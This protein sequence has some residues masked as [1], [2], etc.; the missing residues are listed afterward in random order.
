MAKLDDMAF[1]LDKQQS[2]RATALFRHLPLVI[3]GRSWAT[4]ILVLLTALVKHLSNDRG[5][6]SQL[7]RVWIK[8]GSLDGMNRCLGHGTCHLG[9]GGSSSNP[10]V[11]RSCGVLEPENHQNQV[12]LFTTTKTSQNQLAE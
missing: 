6:E 5:S 2:H 1:D 4:P 8:G 11:A 9:W 10:V 12:F 3:T 7:A